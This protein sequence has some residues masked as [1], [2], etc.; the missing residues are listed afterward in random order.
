MFHLKAGGV[1]VTVTSPKMDDV[2]HITYRG[3]LSGTVECGALK[4]PMAVYL[5]WRPA[6]DKPSAK[7]AVAIEYLPKG[8][9]PDH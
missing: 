4:Q 1:A 6:T 3:D 8:N 7:I 5:T 2:D 9:S